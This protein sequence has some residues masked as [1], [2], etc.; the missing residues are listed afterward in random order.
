MSAKNTSSTTLVDFTT[1][2]IKTDYCVELWQR[3][4]QIEGNLRRIP[5]RIEYTGD[6]PE[7]I[8]V[9]AYGPSLLDTWESVAGFSK[10]ITCSGA[11]PFLLERGIV[12]TWHIEVDPRPHKALLMGVPHPDV[13]Y[14]LASCTNPAV[15]DL[16]EQHGCKKIK[17]W[18]IFADEQFR[19][20]Q[21]YPFPKGEW[22]FTGGS[23]AG[24]RAMVIARFLGHY[25]QTVFG[26]D[27]SFT[28]DR[29][30]HAGFHPKE[31]DHVMVVPT[32]Y[33][34]YISN[35]GMIQAA[36]SFV[37]EITQLPNLNLTLKGDGLIQ[38]KMREHVALGRPL[39]H[40]KRTMMAMR[41]EQTISPEYLEQ[42]KLL[43]QQS[44]VYG[45]SG[46]K[47]A[48]AVK[49]LK[50]ELKAESILDYGS[51]KGTLA[52]ALPFPIWEYDP[53]IPGK[54][55]NP[56]PADLLVCTDVLE[57][58]EPAFLDVV[59]KDLQRCT[60]KGAYI[61]V[62]NT[63]AQKTLPDGRNAHLIVQPM[64]WW[65]NQIGAYFDIVKTIQGG[66]IDGVSTTSKFVCRP[67]QNTGVLPVSL[68]ADPKA[69]WISDT[70][71]QKLEAV[72]LGAPVPDG[73][74]VLAEGL[75]TIAVEADGTTV[76]FINVNQ[77]T[78]WRAKTLLTKEPVTIKWIEAMEP[79]SI[80]FDVGANM[81]GYS[82]WANKRRGAQVYAF[83]PESG[84]YALL[85][86]N[87]VINDVKGAAY[88]VALTNEAKLGQLF[89]SSNEVGGSCHSFDQ[90]IGF[91]L[92]PRDGVPQGSVGLTMDELVTRLGLPYP[93]YVK[94]DVDGLEHNVIAGA[95]KILTNPALK[96]L[97]V[98]VN[99]NLA[100]HRTMVERLR[101]L[102]FDYDQ[103]QVDESMRREGAFVGCA[104][105]VFKN[106]VKYIDPPVV[107][108]PKKIVIDLDEAMEHI[109]KRIEQAEIKRSPFKHI[110]VNEVF[111]P[112]LYKLMMSMMP[113]PNEYS[114]I[115]AARGTKGYP[116]RYV[117][118]NPTRV[119]AKLIKRMTSGTLRK[120]FN[121]KFGILSEKDEAL[122]VRDLP[123]YKIGPHTDSRAK[124][125]TAL[126]YLPK[127]ESLLQAGTSLFV[128]KQ[129][130]F[131]CEG[132]PHYPFE[133]FYL[134]E[135][136]PFAPN[137]LFA[138]PK[139]SVC[140]HGVLPF[141]G[142]GARDVLLYDMQK[143]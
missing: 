34:N 135:T 98:E 83:E 119:F 23:N 71:K 18:H 81:G 90:A 107:A 61:V 77:I 97:I 131:T 2:Q 46:V 78:E 31:F 12:P 30:Q 48:D 9:V 22:M 6:T 45:V 103:A 75:P 54:E 132:G 4:L 95:L 101:T 122:L 116:E 37:H 19:L 55:A 50:E 113:E 17:L 96:G 59:L 89:T 86:R 84:N 8:A 80:L 134:A 41:Y 106:V 38:A 27:A 88:C 56:K 115:E 120:V 87:F 67:K 110:V 16:L 68:D 112:E 129:V 64:D 52:A 40:N 65:R 138:F 53:A 74:P 5:G 92:K 125:L 142:P 99:T 60:I 29:R 7:P 141:K 109:I 114:T 117:C 72:P 73:Q 26:L 51:G 140:F 36:R 82:V 20:D 13:E 111:P 58:V 33:G 1:S 49:K 42:N 104:E 15:L 66:V 139:S 128:P 21:S 130:G 124:M 108:A 57:H 43:H 32:P 126:F 100:E 85:C 63:P 24:M 76:R 91:D 11:L 3:D 127:D 94:I 133:D 69:M 137:S 79:D 118:V 44:A 35:P 39:H 93:N 25:N 10:I 28:P 14:L 121:T 47:Y 102:G 70:D 105:Y 136:V 123:G 143:A 62:N